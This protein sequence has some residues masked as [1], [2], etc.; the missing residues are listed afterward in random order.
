MLRI[1]AAVLLLLAA[2]PAHAQRVG[3]TPERPVEGTLFR[4]TVEGAEAGALRGE[5]AGEAL[6]F[7]AAADGALEALAPVPVDTREAL[8]VLLL[9]RR[10]RGGEDSLRVRV[11]VAPGEY[12]MER[13]TVAPRFGREP[14]AAL[15]AR[16][17]EESARAMAVS[18]ASH[19]TPR[20][21]EG[22]FVRPRPG[23]VTSGFGHGRSFNGQVQSRHMG[24]DLAGAVGAPV[25]AANRAVVALVG[26]FHLGGNVVYLDH[27]AGLV[28]AYLHLSR[29]HVQEGEVVEAGQVIGEVGATGRVTGPHLHW[30]ARYGT[31]TVDP[32]SLPTS[33]P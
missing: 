15:A 26:D 22:E 1:S 23:R 8:E 25:R 14:D 30:I 20:M 13:L 4:I 32:L 6:H 29:T 16:I 3:W 27:G 17:A 5:A 11:P 18:R 24:T 2:A 7:A 19:D 21:W 28:T 31:V 10:A 9:T 12:R 33:S